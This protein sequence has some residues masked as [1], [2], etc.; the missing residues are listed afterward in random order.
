MK[1]ETQKSTR[2]HRRG[3]LK[4]ECGPLSSF[5]AKVVLDYLDGNRDQRSVAAQYDLSQGTLCHWIK[6]YLSDKEAFMEKRPKDKSILSKNQ[7]KD[8]ATIKKQLEEERLKN[9]ALQELID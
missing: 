4:V 9:I 3:R 6:S 8:L 1:K 2:P 7:E 5:K